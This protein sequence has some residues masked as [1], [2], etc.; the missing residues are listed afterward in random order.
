M[1]Q[2][3]CE[4]HNPLEFRHGPISIVR[5]GTAVVVLGGSREQ[6][7]LGDL[8]RDLAGHGA[9]VAK[10]SPHGSRAAV[11]TLR[12]PGGLSDIGRAPLYLPP[13]QLLAYHRARALALNPDEPRNLDHVVVLD[14]S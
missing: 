1:T 4:A 8:E 2:V 9:H 5:P 12:L 13:V 6:R 10:I 3:P 7:Y 11:T 14:R